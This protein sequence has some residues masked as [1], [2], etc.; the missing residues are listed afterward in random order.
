MVKTE[1]YF[2]LFLAIARIFKFYFLLQSIIFAMNFSF[3][4]IFK[5]T[6]YCI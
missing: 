5:S 4:Y 1:Y 6:K 3:M 2:Y